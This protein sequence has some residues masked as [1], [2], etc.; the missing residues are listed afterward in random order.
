MDFKL[1]A[2]TKPFLLGALAG[3]VIISW[4]GFDAFGWKTSGTTESLA[5]RRAEQAVVASQARI[6]SA[7]FNGAKE[8]PARMAELQKTDRY[9]RGD[10]LAKAGFATMTGEK[11]PVSG[12]AQACAE[13][14]V[15]EKP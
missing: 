12:V 9:A 1:P 5:V 2:D 15:S 11:E 14:L 13:L 10:L 7:Q 4:A 3:A 8:L 6:C